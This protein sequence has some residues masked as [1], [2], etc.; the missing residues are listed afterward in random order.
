MA[1][2]FFIDHIVECIM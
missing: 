1:A 2:Y